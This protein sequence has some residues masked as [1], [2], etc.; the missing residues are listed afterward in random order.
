MCAICDYQWP[1]GL[2]CT[3][4]SWF[5]NWVAWA[6]HAQMDACSDDPDYSPGR[7]D[8]STD[9]TGYASGGTW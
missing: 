6:E 8:D 4:G 7:P 9:C 3:C 5:P 2:T 1:S